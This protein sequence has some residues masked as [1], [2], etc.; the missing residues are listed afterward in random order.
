MVSE[1]QTQRREKLLVLGRVQSLWRIP[2]SSLEWTYLLPA[3]A[4]SQSICHRVISETC[5]GP[6]PESAAK[7]I[8]AHSRSSKPGGCRGAWR[9]RWLQT[10]QMKLLSG[11]PGAA[12]LFSVCKAPSSPWKGLCR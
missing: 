7:D 9:D 2:E 11:P 4:S 5:T 8:K 10:G 3:G 1:T 6:T 12:V